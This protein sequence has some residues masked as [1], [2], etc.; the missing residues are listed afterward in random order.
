M[1]DESRSWIHKDAHKNRRHGKWDDI[2]AEEIVLHDEWHEDWEQRNHRIEHGDA[3]WLVEVVFAE[4]REIKGKHH[5]EDQYEECLANDGSGKLVL[6]WTSALRLL[7]EWGE[8]T[9]G[10]VVDDFASVDDFLSTHH[11][12]AG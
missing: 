5:H 2:Y 1:R 7:V 9:V 12:T 6:G 8:Y 11:H 3:A 10:V 4:E